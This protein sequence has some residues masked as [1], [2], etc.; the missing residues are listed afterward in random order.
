MRITARRARF[1]PAPGAAYGGAAPGAPPRPPSPRGRPPLGG[2]APPSS[3]PGVAT[4]LTTRLGPP[5]L[6]YGTTSAYADP[7]SRLLRHP[8]RHPSPD[9]RRPR[10]LPLAPHRPDGLI[11]PLR[12]RLRASP[13]APAGGGTDP[14]RQRA[15]VQCAHPAA[16]RPSIDLRLVP[17]GRV[18]RP[19]PA[20]TPVTSSVCARPP[21]GPC[22]AAG[23][24]ARVVITPVRGEAGAIPA[25]TLP[26][27]PAALAP[28][29]TPIRVPP[30]RR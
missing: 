23:K 27:L 7:P 17:G 5:G 11:P 24:V 30:A 14:H 15:T 29:G 28:G 12:E 21:L 3:G 13:S 18:P 19:G 22:E 9:R 2:A 10:L 8:R 1:R 26:R 20:V 4:R 16:T 25:L 6:P